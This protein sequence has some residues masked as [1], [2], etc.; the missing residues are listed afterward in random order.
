VNVDFAP[1]LDYEEP[2][3]QVRDSKVIEESEGTSKGGVFG[4]KCVRID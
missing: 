1:P 4:G 2:Q 3:K